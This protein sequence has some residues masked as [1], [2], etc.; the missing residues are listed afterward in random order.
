MTDL[1]TFLLDY[2]WKI[3]HGLN[4][5]FFIE[6]PIFGTNYMEWESIELKKKNSGPFTGFKIYFIFQY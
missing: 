2:T 5:F 6:F 1:K 3:Q 4:G